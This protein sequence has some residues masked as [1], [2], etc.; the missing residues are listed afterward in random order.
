[1]LVVVEA[2]VVEVVVVDAQKYHGITNPPKRPSKLQQESD[3]D[4]HS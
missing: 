2:V 1:M 3:S 4:L